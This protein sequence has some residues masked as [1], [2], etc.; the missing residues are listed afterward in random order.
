MWQSMVIWNL[1]QPTLSDSDPIMSGLYLKNHEIR[2]TVVDWT[3]TCAALGWR[4]CWGGRPPRPHGQL[5]SLQQTSPG[6]RDTTYQPLLVHE[7]KHSYRNR[8]LE[9]RSKQKECKWSAMLPWNW[10]KDNWIFFG[11]QSTNSC[12]FWGFLS[13]CHGFIKWSSKYLQ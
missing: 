13:N 2:A 5:V 11:I 8:Q 1:L 6:A 10:A 7:H 9:E 12:G 4:G 3:I